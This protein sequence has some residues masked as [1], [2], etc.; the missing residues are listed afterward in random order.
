MLEFINYFALFYSYLI[1]YN[2]Y[3]LQGKGKKLRLACLTTKDGQPPNS[4]N[5]G[6]DG[7]K[8]CKVDNQGFGVGVKPRVNFVY[9]K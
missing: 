4:G 9:T 1:K 5:Y 6:K 3:V 8:A 2:T 7:K